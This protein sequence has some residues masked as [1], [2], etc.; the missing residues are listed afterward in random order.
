MGDLNYL[1][2][3]L[4]SELFKCPTMRM[5]YLQNQAKIIKRF[6]FRENGKYLLELLWQA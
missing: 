6:P 4:I 1:N 3:I 2:L 5:S